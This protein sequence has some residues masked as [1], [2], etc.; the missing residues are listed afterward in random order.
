M[1]MTTAV[2]G[3]TGQ[4][5]SAVVSALLH[6]GQ[7]AVAIARSA[8]R[9]AGRERIEGRQ[10]SAYT[11]DELAPA[12]KAC[13]RA[14]VTLG[15]PYS[16]KVWLRDWPRLMR[17]IARAALDSQIPFVVL[18]NLYVY[19][20]SHGTPFTER[21]PLEPCSAKGRARLQGFKELQRARSQ[22]AQITVCRSADFIGPG[23]EVTVVP[24][25]GLHAVLS[26]NRHS[27]RWIGD[28]RCQHSYADPRLVSRGLLAVAASSGLQSHD[29]VVLPP[30]EAFSGDDLAQALSHRI[31]RQVRLAPVGQ[32]MIRAASLFSRAAHE[33]V[34][35]IYQV[36][37]DYTVDDALFRTYQPDFPRLSVDDLVQAWARS[38]AR[39]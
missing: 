16:A 10:V 7:R 11:G 28:P 9:L 5:G 34:E 37:A 25:S 29:V 2:I 39:G 17:E 4:I 24:W 32:R 19:G 20:R 21:T 8:P 26:E 18:D 3:A 35:M 15:L 33:Q 22:G 30:A 38:P 13:D 6:T 1:T 23:A 27:L 14:V 12:L 31:E 36:T